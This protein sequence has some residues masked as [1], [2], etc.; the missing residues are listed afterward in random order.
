[1]LALHLDLLGAA[2]AAPADQLVAQV[3]DGVAVRGLVAVGALG[4]DAHAR[5]LVAH[6]PLGGV[7]PGLA[8]VDEL[9]GAKELVAAGELHVALEHRAVGVAVQHVAGDVGRQVLP[10]AGLADGGRRVQERRDRVLQRAQLPHAVRL[11]GVDRQGGR[12]AQRQ[13]EEAEA[14]SHA[15]IHSGGK[16]AR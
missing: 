2:V 7:G 9:V 11:L 10:V 13:W 4:E 12:D 5:V 1:M 16:N 8:V 3:L 15:A 14:V 6:A